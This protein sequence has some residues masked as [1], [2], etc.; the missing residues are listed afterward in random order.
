MKGVNILEETEVMMIPNFTRNSQYEYQ[1][2]PIIDIRRSWKDGEETK[3]YR[4]TD[5]VV[6]DN[7]GNVSC[8]SPCHAGALRRTGIH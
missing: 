7:K 6:Y 2:K 3:T 4:D 5:D 1:I 8:I